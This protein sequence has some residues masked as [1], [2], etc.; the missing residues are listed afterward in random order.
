MITN[1]ALEP[2]TDWQKKIYTVIFE[3]DTPSGKLFDVVLIASI[4]LS[5]IAVMLDSVAGV[6]QS[7][8]SLLYG[9]E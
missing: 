8:G 3:A 4:V 9:V 1:Q 7:Y 6:R 5:V 2:K